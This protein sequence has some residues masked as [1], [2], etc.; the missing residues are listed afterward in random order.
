MFSSTETLYMCSFF[1]SIYIGLSI[2]LSKIKKIM[3]QDNY[4]IK[5]KFLVEK[6][7]RVFGYTDNLINDGVWSKVMI[8]LWKERKTKDFFVLATYE[9]TRKPQTS[10]FLD[11]WKAQ[12]LIEE[13]APKETK[14][15]L[16]SDWITRR[17]KMF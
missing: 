3:D 7:D 10:H 14:N 2:V 11:R 5:R 6:S 1:L 17:E 9:D 8:S 15:Q 4:S 13:K 16:I 12:Q